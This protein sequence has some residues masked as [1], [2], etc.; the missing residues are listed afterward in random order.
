MMPS[1]QLRAGNR[2]VVSRVEVYVCFDASE[3]RAEA[4]AKGPPEATHS[5][6][7]PK[8]ASL[9]DSICCF[10]LCVLAVSDETVSITDWS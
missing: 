5:L 2:V 1:S 6:A 9:S 10:R 3:E 8:M 4:T 7:L